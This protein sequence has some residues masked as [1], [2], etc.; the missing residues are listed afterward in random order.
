MILP[1]RILLP[2][3]LSFISHVARYA[4]ILNTY[5]FLIVE[6]EEL[7]TSVDTEIFDAARHVRVALLDFDA[8]DGLDFSE[9]DDDA[10]W[11]SRGR[12]LLPLGMPVA[13]R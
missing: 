2:L 7:R 11:E 12:L 13:T 9:V 8:R 4:L 5:L 6:Q 10:V 1:C 3:Q